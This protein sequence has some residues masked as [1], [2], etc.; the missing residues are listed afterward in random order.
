MKSIT[1]AACAQLV[2]M[3]RW[4]STTPFGTPSVPLVNS[5]TAAVVGRSGAARQAAARRASCQPAQARRKP[6]PARTS[7]SQT[8]RTGSLHFLDVV[9]EPATL[10]EAPRRQHRADFGGAA[11]RQHAVGAA[12]DVQHRGNT[13]EGKQGEERHRG[14]VRVRQHNAQMLARPREVGDGAAEHAG[15]EDGAAVAQTLEFGVLEGNALA[16]VLRARI[17]QCLENSVRLVSCVAKAASIMQSCSAAAAAS[18]R[19]RPS[20]AGSS[21][22]AAAGGW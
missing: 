15:A 5:T 22:A 12:G 1:A 7:S 6:M 4:L 13:T 10:D 17:Q 16:A 20:R 21:A 8:K 3:L 2:R 18:R 14:A 9:R 19:R 11:G